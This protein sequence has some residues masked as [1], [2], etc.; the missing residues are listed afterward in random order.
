MT[1]KILAI[2]VAAFMMIAVLAAVVAAN[3]DTNGD[4]SFL[5]NCETNGEGCFG[6]EPCFEFLFAYYE[7]VWAFFVGVNFGNPFLFINAAAMVSFN[8]AAEELFDDYDAT[9]FELAAVG[10]ELVDRYMTPEAIALGVEMMRTLMIAEL[11]NFGEDFCDGLCDC[12]GDCGGGC[13]GDCAFDCV[14]WW[15][16][17]QFDIEFM[18]LLAFFDVGNWTEAKA[19]TLALNAAMVEALAEEGIV[20]PEWMRSTQAATPVCPV[21]PNATVCLCDDVTTTAPQD[22]TT[23]ADTTANGETTTVAD[24]TVNGETTTAADT[25]ANG[26]TTTVADTTANGETTT[27]ANTTVNGETT[28]VADTTVN[29][30]TTTAAE[31]TTETPAEGGTNWG[32]IA[33]IIGIV[34]LVIVNLVAIFGFVRI[35]FNA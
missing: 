11:F 5:P 9:L 31:T 27:V 30:E 15:F 21:D 14:D 19:V 32:S 34:V 26:E 13:C 33:G 17:D 23:V 28:T 18:V 35:L 2:L 1:K 25:T 4:Y 20:V 16:M 22:T 10:V 29:G 6:C 24:T 12:W 8:T 7:E 3:T